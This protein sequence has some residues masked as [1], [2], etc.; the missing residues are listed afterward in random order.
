MNKLGCRVIFEPGRL[1]AGNA[2]ILVTEVLYVKEGEGRT[3]VIVDAAMNDLIRPTLYDAYHRIGPVVRD[4]RAARS[5]ATSSARSA[6]PAISSPAAAPCRA[7]SRRPPRRL[8]GRRLRR[9]AGRHLQ[10]PPARAGGAG[11]RRAISPSCAR[12]RPMMS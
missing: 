11:Q 4:G 2:G 10:F 3:F 7:R 9:G 5:S 12:A 6:R 8:F 1:I